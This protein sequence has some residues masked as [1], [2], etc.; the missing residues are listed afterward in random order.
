MHFLSWHLTFAKKMTRMTLGPQTPTQC[1]LE[2]ATGV[3]NNRGMALQQE[4]DWRAKLQDKIQIQILAAA[5]A[6]SLQH[7]TNQGPKKM[8][9][10]DKGS[11]KTPCNECGQMRHWSKECPDKCFPPGPCPACKNK[12]YWKRDC[13]QLQ[14]KMKTGTH[15]PTQEQKLEG[16]A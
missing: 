3:F 16:L 10:S 4:K 5:I 7:Q 13:P 9:L 14:R 1:L 15:F 12:G 8:P 11:S 2:V 6:D